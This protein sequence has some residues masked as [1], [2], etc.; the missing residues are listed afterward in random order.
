MTPEKCI[1][2][3]KGTNITASA[4]SIIAPVIAT[5]TQFP[6]W[7]VSGG[8][9]TASG[10]ALSGTFVAFAAISF[11]PALKTLKGKLK[12]PTGFFMWAIFFGLVAVLRP[13]I[14][15]L[16]VITAVGLASNGGGFVLHKLSN[17]LASKGNND[18]ANLVREFIKKGGVANE[19]TT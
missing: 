4:V 6:L 3:A 16:Y 9:T 5:A 19:R 13:I 11:I 14:D 2:V 15:Q 1:K 7:V 12:N 10:V 18:E 8:E 17:F